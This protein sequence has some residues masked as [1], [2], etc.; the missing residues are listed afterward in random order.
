MN[1]VLVRPIVPLLNVLFETNKPTHS[2][3]L[4]AV[5]DGQIK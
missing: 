2:V 1:T 5:K 4:F 3:G